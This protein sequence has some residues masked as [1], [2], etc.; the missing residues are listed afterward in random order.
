M[1]AA[2]LRDSDNW[3]FQ[4][5]H[6][7][8][9]AMTFRIHVRWPDQSTSDKTNTESR[10]VADF[11]FQELVVMAAELSEKGALGLSY[12][13]DGQQVEYRAQADEPARKFAH[14]AAP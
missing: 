14:R 6:R 11:A 8:Q 4:G 2:A 7:V 3:S 9:A 5:L 13:H 1:V 10:T 12:T